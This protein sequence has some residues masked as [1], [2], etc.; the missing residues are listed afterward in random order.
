MID[1]N[2]FSILCPLCDN[3]KFK[4][5]HGL[6]IHYQSMHHRK[7]TINI[8]NEFFSYPL[9]PNTMFKKKSEWSRH[10]TLK[11]SNYN[12]PSAD[13]F[14]LSDFHINEVKDTLVY[15]IQSH[16]KL[17]TKFAGQQ[18]ISAP[19]T[20]LAFVSIFQNNINCY[21]ICQ[22]KYTCR[23][24]GFDAYNTLAN[25]F[26]QENWRRR[27]YEHGQKSEV[28]LVSDSTVLLASNNKLHNSCHLNFEKPEIIIIW[29][30]K[31]INN[32]D[33]NKFEAG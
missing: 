16:L 30:K 24:G 9:C 19:L 33:G 31:I 7:K 3:K 27:I 4:N 20:K 28:V 6:K 14:T 15:L 5:H 26:N 8:S 11:H 1:S 13:F 29:K 10:E 23:F 25:I 17:H 21:S 12:I 2:T 18:T 32:K 22:Q